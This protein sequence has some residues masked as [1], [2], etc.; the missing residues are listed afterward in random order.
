MIAYGDNFGNVHTHEFS[1]AGFGRASKVD[2]KG[3]NANAIEFLDEGEALLVGGTGYLSLYRKAGKKWRLQ[4]ETTTAVRGFCWVPSS[5]VAVVNRGMHGVI[6]YAIRDAGFE[7]IDS[8]A[9]PEPI[10]RIATTP[11][12][13]FVAATLQRSGKVLSISAS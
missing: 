7:A 1:E 13:E 10:E 9:G 6:R 5:R 2:A 3:R 11:N 8:L 4:S 12:G